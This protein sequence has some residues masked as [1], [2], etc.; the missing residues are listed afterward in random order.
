M[1]DLCKSDWEPGVQIDYFFFEIRRKAQHAGVGIKFVALILTAQLP[2]DKKGKSYDIDKEVA[3]EIVVAD[4]KGL[5]NTVNV[6]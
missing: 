1:Q 2:K 4:S 6:N 3:E 5:I